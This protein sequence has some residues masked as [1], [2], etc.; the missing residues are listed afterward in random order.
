MKARE[1]V[2]AL[3]SALLFEDELSPEVVAQLRAQQIPNV[4]EAR[5]NA[6]EVSYLGGDGGVVC[7]L[8]PKETEKVIMFSLIYVRLHRSPPFAA[9][10]FDTR[11][12]GSRN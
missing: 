5:Q 1:L 9:A 2:A 3:K 4:V 8:L 6:T 11:N 7:H 10:V 12:A